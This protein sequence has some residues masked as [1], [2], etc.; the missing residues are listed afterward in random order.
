MHETQIMV[1]KSRT[2]LRREHEQALRQ[3]QEEKKRKI[4]DLE[5][6]SGNV[7]LCAKRQKSSE[8]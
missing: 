7:Y 3:I 5:E 6:V 8:S 1:E 4:Q 2:A